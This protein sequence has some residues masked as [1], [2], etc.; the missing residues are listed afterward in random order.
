MHSNFSVIANDLSFKWKVAQMW[1]FLSKAIILKEF[2]VKDE[3]FRLTMY[4]GSKYNFSKKEI[5][6]SL[7]ENSYHIRTISIKIKSQEKQLFI[8]EMIPMYSNGEADFD[9]IVSSLSAARLKPL[10]GLRILRQT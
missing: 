9:R 3:N 6:A 8:R 4:N 7:L 5:K 2:H 1:W 10:H